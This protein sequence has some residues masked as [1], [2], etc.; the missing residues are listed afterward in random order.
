M[1]ILNYVCL[2]ASAR[3]CGVTDRKSFSSLNV[4]QALTLNRGRQLL[5]GVS[6]PEPL[7]RPPIVNGHSVRLLRPRTIS[8]IGNSI[9]TV[10]RRTKLIR[11]LALVS[12]TG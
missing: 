2:S 6:G 10:V 3:V 11:L 4:L 1:E 5:S 12:D 8:L 7:T 9:Y